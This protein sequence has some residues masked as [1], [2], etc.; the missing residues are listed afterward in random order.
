MTNKLIKFFQN[1]KLQRRG[2]AYWEGTAKPLTKG[3]A[4]LKLFKYLFKN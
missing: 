1:E 3:Q 2:L 4:T